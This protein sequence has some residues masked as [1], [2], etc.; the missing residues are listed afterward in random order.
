MIEG[1]LGYVWAAYA[2]AGVGLL[3]LVVV[4]VAR[5]AHWS[6]Q[7]NVLDDAKERAK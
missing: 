1:A 5:L 7:A 3:G 4:T 6:R 2:V